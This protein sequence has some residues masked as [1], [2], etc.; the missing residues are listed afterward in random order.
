MATALEST[1][2]LPEPGQLVSVRQHYFVVLDVQ[3]S[4]LPPDAANRTEAGPQHL[5]SLSSV[6]DDA[7]GEELRVLWELEPGARTYEKAA[8]PEPADFD[9]PAKGGT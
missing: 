9:E 1:L 3:K 6:E 2:G 4:S 5:V 8:L 7:L